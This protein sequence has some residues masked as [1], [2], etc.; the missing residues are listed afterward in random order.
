MTEGKKVRKSLCQLT[1]IQVLVVLVAMSFELNAIAAEKKLPQIEMRMSTVIPAAAPAF[2]RMVQWPAK[3][4]EEATNGRVKVTIYPGASLV[5]AVDEY[6]AVQE[7]ISDFA[8]AYTPYTPGVFPVSKL[9]SLPGLFDSNMATSNVVLNILYEKYPAFKNELNPKVKH[10]SSTVMLR[11]EI[12][13]KVPIRKL[14]DLKGKIIGCQD[15]VSAKALA[16]FGASTSVVPVVEMYTSGERGVVQGVVV[17]WGAYTAWRLYEVFK[18]HTRLSMSPGVCHWVMNKKFWNQLTSEEKKKIELLGPWLQAALYQGAAMVGA[19][20]RLKFSPSEKGHKIFELPEEDWDHLRKT[21]KPMWI[22][23]AENME[24]KGI[25]GKKILN[26]AIR[27][28]NVYGARF[29]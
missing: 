23:W 17:A 8:Y 2:K 6:R 21:L 29:G 4:I 18:Y 16:K 28:L 1:I 13:S 3:L 9:F 12:H 11:A 19:V 10:I 22:E 26:E 7:G 14:S 15:E 5:P 25:P 24:K 27:L 20:G